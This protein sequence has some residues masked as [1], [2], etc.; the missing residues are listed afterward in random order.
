M[1]VTWDEAAAYCAWRGELR[2]APAAPADARPSSRR[3]RAATAGSRTRG[4]T[5][6]RPS[7]LDSAVAG[8]SDTVPVG[9]LITG[10]SPYGVLDMAGN[11]FQWTSTPFADGGQVTVK[12]SSWEDFAGRRARRVARTAARRRIAARDHRV[13]L[14]GGSRVTAIIVHGGAGQVAPERHA[15]LRDGVRAAAAA[16]HAILDAGG[17]AL[18]A[19]VAAVRV[20]EDDPE[21]NAGTR[22]GADARRHRRDRRVR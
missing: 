9:E 8:P 10:A 20:L 5:S 6:T 15:R 14:R 12:G 22:L 11:V 7:K 17:R 16:G 2:G 3:R 18:D 1:L 19:V 4:A 13:S 21:F